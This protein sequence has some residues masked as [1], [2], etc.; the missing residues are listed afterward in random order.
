MTKKERTDSELIALG[1]AL[2]ESIDKNVLCHFC[3]KRLYAAIEKDR[4]SQTRLQE[5][6]ASYL[7]GVLND[8][9]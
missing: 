8:G 3:K 9:E 2:A 7:G 5:G 4:Q 1:R 6:L